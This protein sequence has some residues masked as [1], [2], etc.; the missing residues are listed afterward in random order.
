[1]EKAVNAIGEI[2]GFSELEGRQQVQAIVFALVEYEQA[3]GVHPGQIKSVFDSLDLTPYSR[4]SQYLSEKSKKV[5]G[6]KPVFLKSKAGYRLEAT[7]TE[8]IASLFKARPT[9]KVVQKHL[10]DHICKM[11]SQEAEGYLSEALG[12][13][14]HDFWRAAVVMTWCLTY[15]LIRSHIFTNHLT[16]LNARFATRRTPICITSIEDLESVSERDLLDTAKAA[17]ALGK[18]LHKSLVQL[19]D[20]RNSFAHPSGKAVTASIAEAYIEKAALQAIAKIK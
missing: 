1:M 9:K 6:K 12:C 7:A 11:P 10:E 16:V 13:F 19:L 18:E 20:D 3:Q 17:G 15:D 14:T 4:I 8:G 5:R 2:Q